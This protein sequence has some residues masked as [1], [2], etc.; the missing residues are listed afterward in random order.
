[1]VVPAFALMPSPMPSLEQCRRQPEMGGSPGGMH[2][3]LTRFARLSTKM[4]PPV[5]KWHF[6]NLTRI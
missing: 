4:Q 5:E 2:G 6:P 3:P 1:M